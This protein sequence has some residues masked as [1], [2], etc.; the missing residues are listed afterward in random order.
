MNDFEQRKMFK[1]IF[2]QL[3]KLKCGQEEIKL[4]LSAETTAVLK[5][6]DDATTAIAAR[7]QK[8]IDLAASQG[9]VTEAE[10]RAALA[11]EVEKLNALAVD[12]N[13]PVP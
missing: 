6:I 13:N 4:M 2:K 7:I 5:A 10:I 9:S 3:K 1:R 12:P 8:L 11:P